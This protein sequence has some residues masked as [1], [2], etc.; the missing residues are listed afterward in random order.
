MAYIV[1]AFLA[2]TS[3]ILRKLTL[4]AAITATIVSSIIY[5]GLNYV[6][7]EMLGAFFMLGV[8]ATNWHK[9]DKAINNTNPR[10]AGQVLANG[11]IATACSLLA[12]MPAFSIYRQTLCL[13]AAGS[14]AA[15]TADTLSSELGMVYGRRFFNIISLKPEEKGLDGVISV[16]GTLI[17]VVGAAIIAFT[18]CLNFSFSLI[19]WV[20][21]IAGT[22]GNLL[23]SIIGATLER[24]HFL[25]NNM[26]NL[27][28]T[29]TGALVI[30]G[31][32]TLF[33]SLTIS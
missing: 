20:I 22:L 3:F 12:L 29:L 18:Y 30:L 28:N 19:F 9:R 8:A 13:M 23:D 7:L 24:K 5:L 17:G 4:V 27:F 11:G 32:K 31:L 25:N 14:F 6:G 10:D 26:V 33:H 2:L 1:I 16:E 21:V 15:V